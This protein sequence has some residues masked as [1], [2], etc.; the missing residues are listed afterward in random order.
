MVIPWIHKSVAV[1]NTTIAIAGLFLAHAVLAVFVLHDFLILDMSIGMGLIF[2]PYILIIRKGNLSF[3]YLIPSLLLLLLLWLIPVRTFFF[4]TSL[5]VLLFLCESLSGKTNSAFI[6]LI[7]VLSPV[8]QFFNNMIGFP[9]RLW[10]S[11][12]TGKILMITGSHVEIHGNLIGLDGE[13]FSVDPA[14]AG[15]QMMRISFII[16]LFILAHLQ[17]KSGKPLPMW[18]TIGFLTATFLLNIVSNLFRIILLITFRIMP[19]NGFHDVIGIV[20]LLLYVI[21]PLLFIMRFIHG[22]ESVIKKTMLPASSVKRIILL[23]MFLFTLLFFAALRINPRSGE[24]FRDTKYMIDGCR[25]EILKTGIIKF[26]SDSALI[27]IKPLHFYSAEHNPMICWTGS[28]YEFT[29]IS[30]ER[31]MN[32][33]IYT[34]MLTRGNEKIYT[35]WW[36]DNCTTRTIDQFEWRWKAVTGKDE[37][38]LVNV[39]AATRAGLNEEIRKMF[40]RKSI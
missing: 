14:C 22:K 13:L 15:L 1:T 39:N 11:E 28:G 30:K 37:F 7:L 23:N 35:A 36:F 8:Y 40:L 12:V 27:Y 31:I 34:G 38:S 3:R 26:E 4:L 17:R 9:V 21:L 6:I 10:L 5:F 18:I 24:V 32:V 2:A 16:A 33:E 20:C 19:D 25:K 29:R